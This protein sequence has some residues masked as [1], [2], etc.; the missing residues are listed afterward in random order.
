MT[1]PMPAATPAQPSSLT[2]PP[3][4]LGRDEVCCK[5]NCAA[6]PFYALPAMRER[7]AGRRWPP[8]FPAADLSN[9]DRLARSACSATSQQPSP[10]NG[11]REPLECQ[12]AG[13]SEKLPCDRKAHP[14]SP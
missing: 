11:E 12:P 5:L 4:A 10:P 2:A 9:I 7:R 13:R 6:T 1:S 8:R 3:F 14:P